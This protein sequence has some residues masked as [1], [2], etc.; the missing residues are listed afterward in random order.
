M[1]TRVRLV[2]GLIHEG[3]VLEFIEKYGDAELIGNRG[4]W[5]V[6]LQVGYRKDEEGKPIYRKDRD[7]KPRPN[8]NR[9]GEILPY[10]YVLSFTTDVISYE[11]AW[12]LVIHL[13]K[14]MNKERGVKGV[15]V[16]QPRPRNVQQSFD[17]QFD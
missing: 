7:G 17:E 4:Q 2:D 16:R 1:V 10:E 5:V 9:Q 15:Y 14:H 11:E 12:D 3:K 6:G 13:G 8:V